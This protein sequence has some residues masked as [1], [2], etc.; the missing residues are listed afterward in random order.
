MRGD[1]IPC[2]LLVFFVALFIYGLGK[3][4][5]LRFERGDVYPAYSSLRTDPLGTKAFY[6]SLVN[7]QR[8][9]AARSYVPLTEKTL[10]Q[11]T[12]VFYLGTHPDDLNFINEDR[13]EAFEALVA[14]GARVVVSFFPI[15]RDESTGICRQPG[16]SSHGK[17]VGEEGETETSTSGW[18]CGQS[19]S[20]G[21]RWG[22]RFGVDEGFK[23]RTQAKRAGEGL[24]TDM[25]NLISWCTA[26]YFEALQAPWQIVYYRDGYPVIIARELGEGTIVL[27]SDSYLF[28]NEA[29]REERHPTLLAWF[30]GKNTDVVFDE[31]HHGIREKPTVA[32]LIRKYRLH[33][34]FLGI[35]F[36]A[37]LFVWKS[38]VPFLPPRD[39]DCSI[40]GDD[41]TSDRDAT[42]GLVSLL[43]R[44]IAPQ[45]ILGVCFEEWKKSS[46]S[47]IRDLGDKLQ[48]VQKVVEEQL[49]PPARQRNPVQDYQNI[50]CILTERN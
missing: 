46:P 29:L 32:S 2:V 41:G 38:S 43:R 31:T 45:D 15:H 50:Q 35:V 36:L 17:E 14:A 12:T 11:E 19:V 44:N 3:L 16:F 28:S 21:E 1:R 49:A 27:S 4:L 18:T 34:L 7:L 24:G 8:V 37:G 6:E 39:D 25:P 48:S 9:S 22:F 5:L 10:S 13:I 23:E 20:L 26:L 40:G 30:L 42:A 33:G 47:N